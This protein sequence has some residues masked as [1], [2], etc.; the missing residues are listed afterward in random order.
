[1]EV[2]VANEEF[3]WHEH[4]D[5]SGTHL[6][7]VVHA[8]LAYIGVD[9]DSGRYVA[10]TEEEVKKRR[11]MFEKGF[12]WEDALSRAFGSRM[13]HRPVESIEL[14]GV[15]MSPDGIGVDAETGEV[16]VEEYKCTRMNPVRG[17]DTVPRWIMQVKAYCRA[18]GT[19]LCIFRI[20]HYAHDEYKVYRIRFTQQ[21]LEENWAAII[22]YKRHI[23]K[24]GS[25]GGQGQVGQDR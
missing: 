3:P 17:P 1:M 4:T 15:R 25:D 16:C 11:L 5:R 12:L 19:T 14:D 9:A 20:F 8:Y 24:G 22:N 18:Y 10:G 23:E 2:T 21:E 7:D 13:A 6:S